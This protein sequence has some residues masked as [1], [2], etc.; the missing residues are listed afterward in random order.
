MHNP[1][2]KELPPI[3]RPVSFGPTDGDDGALK[4]I[5]LSPEADARIRKAEYRS[6]DEVARDMRQLH[7]ERP[8]T[9]ET[10]EGDSLVGILPNFSPPFA[11]L[12]F[13]EDVLAR[14]VAFILP[15]DVEYNA[16]WKKRGGTGAFMMLARKWDRLEPLCAKFD[17]NIFKMLERHPDR[18]DD[19]RDL[20]RYLALV[21]SEA[22]HQQWIAPEE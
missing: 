15:K 14:D 3:P 1:T 9:N 21:E 12:N 10:G 11:H 17:Y 16:S 18:I 22:L 13:I 4:K 7:L 20:R 8:A 6:D 2:E 5:D 19:V